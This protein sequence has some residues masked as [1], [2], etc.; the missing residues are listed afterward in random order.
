MTSPFPYAPSK[1]V[2]WS[3]TTALSLLLFSILIAPYISSATLYLVKDYVAPNFETV[4]SAETD[5]SIQDAIPDVSS[6]T[7]DAVQSKPEQDAEKSENEL[8]PKKISQQHQLA[9]LLIRSY[10]TPAFAVVLIVFFVSVVFL[11]PITEEFLFRV[12]LQSAF[13]KQLEV[14]PE[15][16][17]PPHAFGASAPLQ[18]TQDEKERL[19]T[20]KRKN[21]TARRLR[22]AVAVVIPA[23]IFASLHIASPDNVNAPED[24]KVVYNLALAHALSNILTLCVGFI[25]LV[26]IEGATFAD[27]GFDVSFSDLVRTPLNSLGKLMKSW[28]LGILIMCVVYPIVISVNY[29]FQKL[30]PDSIVA[31]IPIF[32]FA[33]FAGSVYYR[34]RHFMTT[35]GMH[36]TLNFTS[37]ILLLILIY[38]SA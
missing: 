22:L 17:P 20:A 38:Q 34:S 30:F 35:L 24:I 21:E 5:V 7:N 25:A 6:E 33:L 37:F 16:T 12:V 8:T 13:E 3:L 19:E 14:Y 4:S 23:L 1:G 11:A 9:R 32:I 2:P 26:K 27:L 31:P 10:H 28:S 29:A 36:M 18:L 15:E